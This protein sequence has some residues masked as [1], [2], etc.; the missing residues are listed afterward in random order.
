MS[1]QL[2]DTLT[3]DK[4]E[5]EALGDLQKIV[6]CEFQTGLASVSYSI[7]GSSIGGAAKAKTAEQFYLKWCLERYS[8]E[9]DYTE[10]FADLLRSHELEHAMVEPEILSG[11]DF[12]IFRFKTDYSLYGMHFAKGEVLRVAN[13]RILEPVTDEVRTRII[14]GPKD[15]SPVDLDLLDGKSPWCLGVLDI[16]ITFIVQDQGL[17]A[18]N[19]E[20]KNKFRKPSVS[21]L[22]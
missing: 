19:E 13:H 20:Q 3:L 12:G 22:I 14:N 2:P 15:L 5:V 17:Y 7:V 10:E 21:S 1:E 8:D 9:C 4:Y 6:S 11:F 16:A 18:F